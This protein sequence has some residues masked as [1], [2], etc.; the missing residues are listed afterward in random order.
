MLIKLRLHLRGAAVACC[1][2]LF[3]AFYAPYSLQAAQ[4]ENNGAVA[5]S[6][7]DEAGIDTDIG[8]QGNLTIPRIAGE[9][10][11]TDFANMSL[12]TALARSMA[13]IEGFTQRETNDGDPASQR[14]EVYIG[15]DET[16]LHAIFLAFD[17][18]PEQIRAN[19]SSR[20]NIDGDDVVE[21]TIDT[22][23]DQRTAFSFRVT[24]L[25]IQWDARWTEGSSLRAGFDTTLEAVWDSEGQP[26]DRGYMVKMAIPLRSL[27]FPD[28]EEQTWRVQF[29]R[30]IPRASEWNYWPSYSINV[31]G[32]LNQTALMTG[33]SNVSPGNNYQIIPFI[34]AR[35]V[36]AIDMRASG[37]PMLDRTS[38]TDVGVD[39]K[40]VFNDSMVLDVTINPDFS[41][42]ESDEP[43]VT[44]NERFEVQFP[45]RRPFFVENADFFA[46]DS[47]LIF[48]RRI[49]DPEAGLRFTGRSG[50]YGFGA[51]L[52]NDEAPGLNRDVDHPLHGEKANIGIIR[53][54]RD[55]SEQDRVGFLLSDRILA[56]GHNLVG[57]I[58]GRFRL[59]DNWTTQMQVVG[60]D[61][62]P[63][64]GGVSSTGYQR[65]IQVNRVG[66]TVNTHTHF[67]ETTPDFRAELGF[68]QRFFRSDTSGL[69]NRVAL[70]FF[71]EDSSVS[72]WS[73]SL[74]SVYMEDMAGTKIYHQNGPG[75]DIEFDTTSF[76]VSWTD[77]N[78]VLLPGDFAGLTSTQNYDYDNWQ[79]SFDDSS[80][81]SLEFG[82]SYRW[83]TTL[84]LVPPRGTLPT[85][86][87]TTRVDADMLW[88]PIDRLRVVNTY[89]NTKL[90][91]SGGEKVFSNEIVRSNWNYQFTREW[92]LRF[93]A[94]YEKTDAGPA[95]RLADNEN[96]NFDLLLR[97]VI[98]PWSAFYAG[99]N[100]NRSNFD[101]VEREGE[102]EL[103]VADDL[104][105]D[106]NQ[107]FV[108]FSYLF[109]R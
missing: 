6:D 88:R 93:I 104:R 100:T 30:H 9:P 96:L 40:F 42:V 87:D 36:E 47:T 91:M 60:T 71:P 15:Y 90:E 55:I 16:K 21:M 54:F 105:R 57:S 97:Y 53:G 68:Q 66:R 73:T 25:G 75:F 45:E 2:F 12:G 35:D 48:T 37:G 43:Q 80:F 106:G 95:T 109:Q 3:C 41:Q 20:E 70:N 23:N 18:D 107:F 69:H 8:I 31:D 52:I 108:K 82:V 101:I 102:R 84:N 77:Y 51:I 83:G 38:E 4:A 26:T 11:F 92:S 98:N 50:D 67:I 74:F 64:G 76:G 58:D 65:N 13:K 33:V 89:L 94:Q 79:L 39:A 24:P 1:A 86:A 19:M 63:V 28:E 78:E 49:V 81:S 72:R 22:F 59:G 14:T 56:D 17:D 44:V 7:A 62:E 85:V 29:G 103:V 10:D 34:F 61:S 32:R 99:Y 27:R 46:T 5:E